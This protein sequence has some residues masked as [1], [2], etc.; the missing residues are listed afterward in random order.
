MA[1]DHRQLYD[2]PSF[3]PQDAGLLRRIARELAV[4][5]WL[6]FAYL[7]AL[8]VAC[9]QAP[10]GSMRTHCLERVF[11]LLMFLVTTLVVVRGG[12]LRHSFW[13]PLMY[14]LA[15]YGTV[16][17]SYFFF[18]DLLPIVNAGSLD[19]ELY[20]LDLALFGFEPAMAL[21]TIVGPLTTEWFAF[22][23]FGYFFLLALHVIPI[24][25]FSKHARLLAEF[26]LGMLFVFCIG[27]T[28]YMLV[29]GY[30]PYKAMADQFENAFPRGMWLDMV[31]A[32]VN[33]GGAQ[34]DI[35]P[36][37]HTAAPTFIALFSF[38]HRD[39]LPFRYTWAPAAFFAV[40]IIVATMFLRWHYIIDVIAGMTLATGALLGAVRIVRWD[41]ARRRA[42]S[43]SPSWPMFFERRRKSELAPRSLNYYPY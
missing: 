18:H 40:N 42:G 13:A 5:D 27:H 4:Q 34:K 35:F 41:A 24:L 30:G 10:A 9:L 2:T 16:Q 36:S 38:R 43:L 15:L 17:L 23:Y 20:R 8:N 28:V 26:A 32:T 33:A 39:K 12:L 1:I 29:P 25:M 21:D 3:V 22:F 6:V 31:M 37:L 7:I 14:R 11:G 19:W